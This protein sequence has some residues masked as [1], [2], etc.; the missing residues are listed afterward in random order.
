MCDMAG[1]GPFLSGGGERGELGR[2]AGGCLA[3]ALASWFSC[4]V[5]CPVHSCPKNRR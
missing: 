2:E 1:A 3:S 5:T 4:A